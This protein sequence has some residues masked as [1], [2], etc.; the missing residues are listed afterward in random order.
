MA[1]PMKAFPYGSV[2]PRV[3]LHPPPGPQPEPSPFSP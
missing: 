3:P 2:D 1:A